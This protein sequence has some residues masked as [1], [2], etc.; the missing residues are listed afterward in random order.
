MAQQ[1][2]EITALAIIQ[3]GG[4]S[5]KNVANVY[6]FRRTGSSLPVVKANV[7][8]AFQTAIGAKVLLALEVDYVMTAN[9]VRFYDD[10]LDPP[11]SFTETGVGAIAAPRDANFVSGTIQLKTGL[12]GRSGR[13]SKHY[14]PFAD[15]DIVGDVLTA[16]AQTRLNA[17]LTAILAGFTDS[18]G[19]V[20]VCQ[21]RSTRPP[22]QY[23]VNPV[24]VVANDVTSGKINKTLGTMKRRKVK[25]VN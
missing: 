11:A 18:D 4:G 12:R 13:G 5:S 21:I 14:S 16:G 9:T 25:T 23:R 17:I 8:A 20:W 24:T 15:A 1:Y 3:A 7:E 22:A 6:H 19:N 10:A 2:V